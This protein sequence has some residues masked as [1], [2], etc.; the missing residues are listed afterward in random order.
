MTDFTSTFLQWMGP[1]RRGPAISEERVRMYAPLLPPTLLRWWQEYGA[2]S[3]ADGL[4]WIVDPEEWADVRDELM[5]FVDLSDFPRDVAPIPVLRT[6]YG[7]VYFW[8]RTYGPVL[9]VDPQTGRFAGRPPEGPMTDAEATFSAWMTTF[10][11]E[12][13][14]L[15]DADSGGPLYP[16]AVQSHGALEPNQAFCIIPYPMLGGRPTP[17]TL[18]PGDVRVMVAICAQMRQKI[19]GG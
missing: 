18:D 7:R 8:D 6:A 3:F 12:V 14:D 10:S 16:L 11:R 5:S 13:I 9:S 1:A 15:V 4:L 2:G 17:G 19:L